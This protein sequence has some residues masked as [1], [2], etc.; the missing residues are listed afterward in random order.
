MSHTNILGLFGAC[1]ALL[2]LNGCYYERSGSTGW[3]Y[4]FT[5][6]GGFERSAY[7]EPKLGLASFSLKAAHTRW[8]KSTTT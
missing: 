3:A 5:E 7:F 8:D 6:N 1:V 4:N 2:T